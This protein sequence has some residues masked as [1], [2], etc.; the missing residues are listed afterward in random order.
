[1]PV[2]ANPDDFC[3]GRKFLVGRRDDGNGSVH[4]L[5]WQPNHVTDTTDTNAKIEELLEA[6]FSVRS[7]QRLH[8]ESQL[9]L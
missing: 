4:T 5:Q 7:M 3:N 1:M 6:V 2:L 9:G 8:K